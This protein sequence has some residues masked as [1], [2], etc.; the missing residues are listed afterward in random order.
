RRSSAPT[1]RRPG[2][3]FMLHSKFLRIGSVA[4]TALAASCGGGGGGGDNGGGGSSRPPPVPPRKVGHSFV[5]VLENK[6]YARTF[7]N[8]PVPSHYLGRELPQ[9]GQLLTHYYGTGHASLDNYISMVSG[10]PPN[11]WTQADSPVILN[12]VPG[13]TD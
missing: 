2:A 8:D 4:L 7:T 5:I 11:A 6:G 12:V 1:S 3:E 10:Q 13:N 9:I